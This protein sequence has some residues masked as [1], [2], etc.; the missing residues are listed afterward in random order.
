MRI[1]RHFTRFRPN[2]DTSNVMMLREKRELNMKFRR[3]SS[4]TGSFLLQEAKIHRLDKKMNA[5]SIFFFVIK[6]RK[7]IQSI[8]QIQDMQGK[9]QYKLDS[10]A[11]IFF[12]VFSIHT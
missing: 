9:M 7:L 8:T 2:P 5:L 10:R 1:E 11:D 4:L 3:S 6:Q 12:S